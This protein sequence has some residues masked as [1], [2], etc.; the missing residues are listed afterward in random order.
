MKNGDIVNFVAASA[1]CGTMLALIAGGTV[2]MLTSLTTLDDYSLR[3]KSF[4]ERAKQTGSVFGTNITNIVA[5][6]VSTSLHSVYGFW[7]GVYYGV[8]APF[9]ETS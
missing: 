6:T 1:I 5:G 9:S 8:S 3:E 2:G 4:L 7:R